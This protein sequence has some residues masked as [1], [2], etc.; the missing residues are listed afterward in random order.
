MLKALSGYGHVVRC[1]T[2]SKGKNRL[3]ILSKSMVTPKRERISEVS[4]KRAQN[5][6]EIG[7]LDRK[8]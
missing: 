8:G 7:R 6:G 5:V 4:K 3:V 2:I 1:K